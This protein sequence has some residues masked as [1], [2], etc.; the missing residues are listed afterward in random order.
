ML[1][2]LFSPRN[3]SQFNTTDSYSNSKQTALCVPFRRPHFD[4]KDA[5]LNSQITGSDKQRIVVKKCAEK[6]V[7][8]EVIRNMVQFCSYVPKQYKVIFGPF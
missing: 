3:M 5:C 8:R 4:G 2:T 7:K 6:M 1:K